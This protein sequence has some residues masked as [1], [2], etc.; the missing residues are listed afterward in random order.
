MIEP[1]PGSCGLTEACGTH[2]AAAG[3]LHNDGAFRAKISPPFTNSV[4]I[5]RVCGSA[6]V[7]PPLNWAILRFLVKGIGWRDCAAFSNAGLFAIR[8][9]AQGARGRARG[10]LKIVRPG[11]VTRE[12][13]LEGEG[14]KA[15][16]CRGGEEAHDGNVSKIATCIQPWSMVPSKCPEKKCM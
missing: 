2:W 12:R 7:G 10:E 3:G 15:F 1:A 16:W 8:N 6:V 11:A 4:E 13:F 14:E 9:G 5:W